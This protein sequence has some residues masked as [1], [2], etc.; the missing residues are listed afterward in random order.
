MTRAE[1]QGAVHG[2]GGRLHRDAVARVE[3][4]RVEG[5]RAPRRVRFLWREGMEAVDKTPISKG[6]SPENKLR[7]DK[8]VADVAQQLRTRAQVP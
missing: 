1:A 8:A 5:R 3:Y 4:G 2:E 6:T 7:Q